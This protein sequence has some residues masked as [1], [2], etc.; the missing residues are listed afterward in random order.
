MP[1]I[2]KAMAQKLASAGISTPE[3]LRA[4]GSKEAFF[5]LKLR[6]SNVCLVHLFALEGAV[7]GVAYNQLPE[8]VKTDLKAY[9]DSL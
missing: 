6:Y 7:A 9:S 1:N 2:G 8:K 3:E 4:L 5:R